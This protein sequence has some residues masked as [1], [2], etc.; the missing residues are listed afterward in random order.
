LAGF[1]LLAKSIKIVLMTEPIKVINQ[2]KISEPDNK[3]ADRLISCKTAM[4]LL[5]IS[6][7][8]TIKKYVSKGL[9]KAYRQGKNI[10]FDS[11]VVNEFKS[12]TEVF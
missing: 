7:R 2:R 5:G 6:A 11:N 8:N 12:N 4:E 9:I 1:K 3:N 10:Y